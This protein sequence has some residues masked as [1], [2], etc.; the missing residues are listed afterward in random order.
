MGETMKAGVLA[1]VGLVALLI[2]GCDGG[3][4]QY[5]KPW[6][7]E[8][9]VDAVERYVRG[10]VRFVD[11][12][13]DDFEAY[14]DNVLNGRPVS[15]SRFDRVM[16]ILPDERNL[17]AVLGKVMETPQ[18]AY[19]SDQDKVYL[20]RIVEALTA[21]LKNR[22]KVMVAKVEAIKTTDDAQVSLTELENAFHGMAD[23]IRYVKTMDDIET[24]V[25]AQAIKKRVQAMPLEETI[26]KTIL[27]R[28]EGY[29]KEYE[30]R[31]TEI[32]GAMYDAAEAYVKNRMP[33]LKGDAIGAFQMFLAT[34]AAYG[35]DGYVNTSLD[36]KGY[37]SVLPDG[38]EEDFRER[39]RKALKVK[40]MEPG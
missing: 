36:R 2:G 26:I 31:K 25:F 39:L 5:K 30:L 12:T 11:L 10:Y 17:Y 21:E 35:I 19:L 16:A 15:A 29:R 27:E 37:Y 9:E 13:I 23:F 14:A 18:A 6:P 4:P 34:E 40:A 32:S 22:R 3:L 7:W 20:D 8:R 28:P 33:P 1:L 38:D 24:A